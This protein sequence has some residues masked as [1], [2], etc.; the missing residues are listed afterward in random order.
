MTIMLFTNSWSR[1][2]TSVCATA[3]WLGALRAAEEI[4]REL[5]ETD[6]ARA[7]GD[8]FWAGDHYRYDDGGGSSSDSIM[9]DQL[10]GQWYADA[11]G[12]GDLVHPARVEAALRTI[13]AATCAGSP[14]ARWAP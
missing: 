7:Y 4:G 10:A 3:F 6:R 13:H 5:G 8:D 14:M 2:L 1:K 9:A 12:L 11:T